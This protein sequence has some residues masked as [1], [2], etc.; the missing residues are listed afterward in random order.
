MTG[1][2]AERIV[3][4]KVAILGRLG[5]YPMV[6][7]SLPARRLLAYLALQGR[8]VSRT[9]AA[10]NLW[11]DLPEDAG[12]AN[13]RRALWHVPRGW[14]EAVGD[15]LALSADVDFARAQ[16]VA[17]HALR[18]EALTYED[19]VLLSNDVLPGWHEEWLLAGQEAFRLLRVE[20][21]EAACRM[22]TTAG[23]LA[24]AAQ[25][26]MAAL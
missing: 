1:G 23:D 9:A 25:A 18:G 4:R 21:L 5:V 26:G 15:E 13:L 11:L 17:A 24:L 8:P 7:L 20:A 6:R 2:I 22:M 10:G 3:E 12:R 19:I 16:A 14:I